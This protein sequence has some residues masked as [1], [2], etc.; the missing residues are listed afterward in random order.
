MQRDIMMAN[1]GLV[2]VMV[3]DFSKMQLS[4]NSGDSKPIDQTTNGHSQTQLHWFAL[5]KKVEKPQVN[6]PSELSHQM[7]Q[8]LLGVDLL[9][10]LPQ[11]LLQKG[12]LVQDKVMLVTRLSRL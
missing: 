3:P 1:M 10:D 6:Q 8:R 5:L 4:S 11:Q 12:L 9:P 7:Q 2:T